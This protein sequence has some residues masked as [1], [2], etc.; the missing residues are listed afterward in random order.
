MFFKSF[1]KCFDLLSKKDVGKHRI[2]LFSMLQSKGC[3][4]LSLLTGHLHVGTCVSR[5][6]SFFILLVAFFG[7]LHYIC[8]TLHVMP[9][10]GCSES[11]HICKFVTKRRV[12][13]FDPFDHI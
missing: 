5:F 13:K 7:R 9:S 6:N 8:L 4:I 1:D 2:D 12:Q 11:L 10:I 3:T